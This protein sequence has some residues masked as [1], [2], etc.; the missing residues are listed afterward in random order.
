M[1]TIELRK[2]INI[3]EVKEM[4]RKAKSEQEHRR[5]FAI[6]LL[7]KGEKRET[8]VRILELGINS[9]N[10]WIKRVNKE[11]IKGLKTQKG[12]G[13]KCRLKEEEKKEIQEDIL[14]SPRSLGYKQSNWTGKLLMRRMREKYGVE[15]KQANIYVLLKSLGISY[16]RPTRLYG[17]CS[18]EKQ[19]DF[20][21]NFK[22]E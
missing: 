16:Q 1:K 11:G 19:E 4:K 22:V 7:L 6:E 9:L 14:K 20:K 2:Q 10:L 8:I 12:R 13:A 18:K 17:E 21:K 5:F 15:Y 3:E